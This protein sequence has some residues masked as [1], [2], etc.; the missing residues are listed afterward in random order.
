TTNIIVDPCEPATNVTPVS[1][2][3][4]ATAENVPAGYTYQF[5][6]GTTPGGPYPNVVSGGPSSGGSP[7]PY[8]ANV[9]G[10]TPG[11]TYYYTSEVLNPA[12]QVVA[13]GG[14]CTFT[15]VGSTSPGGF[16]YWCGA[17][18]DS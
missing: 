6:Y 10:L 4:N 13:G 15:T 8:S 9:V 5:R 14:E 1:A 16:V 12:Q 7:D 18:Y 2:T 17:L 3:L 11:T